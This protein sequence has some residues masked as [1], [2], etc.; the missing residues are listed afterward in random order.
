ME[1]F[2]TT[3]NILFCVLKK[4]V[5]QVWMTREWEFPLNQYFDILWPFHTSV[6]WIPTKANHKSDKVTQQQCEKLRASQDAQSVI[7]N[8]GYI[9]S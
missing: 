4:K 1:K 3:Q 8:Q 2:N 7:K 6:Y 5:L 9:Y